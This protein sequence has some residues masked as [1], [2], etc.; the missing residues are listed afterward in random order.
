MKEAV[1]IVEEDP[2]G[3]QDFLATLSQAKDVFDGEARPGDKL[4]PVRGKELRVVQQSR[5]IFFFW[6][7]LD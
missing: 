6:F 4:F 3:N 7:R 1:E 5:Q 2:G